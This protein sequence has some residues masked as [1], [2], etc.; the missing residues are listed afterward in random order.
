MKKISDEERIEITE[1]ALHVFLKDY[2]KHFKVKRAV[3][4]TRYDS[5]PVLVIDGSV[6]GYWMR[7]LL[8]YFFVEYGLLDEYE[9]VYRSL[10]IISL[11]DLSKYKEIL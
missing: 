10:V 4:K 3:A 8:D 5:F 2:D 6:N 7:L 9:S 1:R 11:R